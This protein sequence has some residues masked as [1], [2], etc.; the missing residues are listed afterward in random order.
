MAIT[1]IFNFEPFIH[2]Q[3]FADILRLGSYLNAMLQCCICDLLK[4]LH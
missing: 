2:W 3:N 4:V 1:C